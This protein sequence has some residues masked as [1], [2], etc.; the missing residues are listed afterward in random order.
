MRTQSGYNIV[1]LLVTLVVASVLVTA[2][3]P[4]LS[5]FFRTN[6]LASATN[7]VVLALQLARA[8]A[9]RRGRPVS[10]CRSLDGASCALGTAW[11]PGWIVF[12]DANATGNPSATAAGAELIRV[13][14]GVDDSVLL[15]GP[16][17][18][19]FS[20]DGSANVTAGSEV[21][22]D[23]RVEDCQGQQRRR[24]M[25]NRLGRVRTA[26]VGCEAA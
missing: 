20:A 12:Q 24:V 8:E 15:T 13:F 1:E 17:F 2:A 6:R 22:F 3:T 18:A 7:E 9:A 16:S 25:I 10:V 19:R 5:A 26:T 14:E 4:S 21:R 23:V 11:A